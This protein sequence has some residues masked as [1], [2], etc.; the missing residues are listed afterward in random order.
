MFELKGISS[1]ELRMLAKQA[2]TLAEDLEKDQPT[3]E[4]ALI[5]GIEDKSYNTTANGRV[6]SYVGEAIIV[7]GN[8][9]KWKAVGHRPTGN[10]FYA[11]DGYIEFIPMD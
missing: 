7:M 3:K 9:R 11:R 5:S 8:G 4:L 10:A 1:T 6:A 2:E